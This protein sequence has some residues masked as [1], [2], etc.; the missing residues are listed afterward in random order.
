MKTKRAFVI[1]FGAVEASQKLKLE[2]ALG[3]TKNDL[4]QLQCVPFH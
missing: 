3:V 1:G 4:L 2:S